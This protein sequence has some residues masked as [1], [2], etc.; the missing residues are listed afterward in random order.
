MD[1][2]LFIE[3]YDFSVLDAQSS[4][5]EFRELQSEIKQFITKCAQELD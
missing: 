2:R 5:S 4:S 1:E 3:L